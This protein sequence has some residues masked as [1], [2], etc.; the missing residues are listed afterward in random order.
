MFEG[1][2]FLGYVGNFSVSPYILSTGY[3]KWGKPK[4]IIQNLEFIGCIQN[5][6]M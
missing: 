3:M 5:Q 4:I 6:R 1:H 2:Y